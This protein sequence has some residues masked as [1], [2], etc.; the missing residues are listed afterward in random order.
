[1]N[2]TRR[3]A[4][5]PLI[6]QQL[7][8]SHAAVDRVLDAC[9]RII[10]REL[11]A[12]D[13]ARVCMVSEHTMRPAKSGTVLALYIECHGTIGVPYRVAYPITVAMAAQIS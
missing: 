13:E 1:V 10:K 4:A 6:R 2:S 7:G 11:I 5:R 3:K 9:D 8:L 12:T